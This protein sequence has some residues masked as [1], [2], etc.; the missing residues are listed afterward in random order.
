MLTDNS[1]QKSVIGTTKPDFRTIGQRDLVFSKNGV[2]GALTATDYK[3]PKQILDNPENFQRYIDNISDKNSFVKK[4]AQT[5]LNQKGYIPKMF[6][7]YNNRE[8]TD[9]CPTLTTFC[10]NSASVSGVV[11]TE[12]DYR[13]R[14]ITP[15]ECWR[16]M[17]FNDDDVK[18]VR[19][20]GMS[21]S[22]LYKQA[23]NSIV[24][25]C[26]SLIMKHL[27]KAQ[28]ENTYICTDEM[29]VNNNCDSSN[30]I[31]EGTLNGGKWDKNLE[32]NRRVYSMNGISPT[33][34]TCGG[35]NTEPKI[36][37]NN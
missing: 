33:I 28:I 1:F 27:Y 7:P 30:L 4:K 9:F 31:L 11:K 18:K 3:Q 29:I 10:G 35:G 21:D 19:D 5:I 37:I 14:K 15:T 26:I 36:M 17:G 6:N 16:L 8:I 34:T 20:I 2:M 23:G 24:T 32:S 25:N 12:S 13:I 22:S